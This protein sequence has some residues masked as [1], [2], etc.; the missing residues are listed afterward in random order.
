MDNRNRR[1]HANDNT[2]NLND[3]RTPFLLLLFLAILSGERTQGQERLFISFPA[4]EGSRVVF[5][6]SSETHEAIRRTSPSSAFRMNYPFL[7]AWMNIIAAENLSEAQLDSLDAR[8]SLVRSCVRMWLAHEGNVLHSEFSILVADTAFFSDA[9]LQ[10]LHHSITTTEFRIGS[11]TIEP[12]SP[13]D[14]QSSSHFLL[15][16]PLYANEPLLPTDNLMLLPPE[17]TASYFTADK[18][19]STSRKP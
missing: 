1:L 12:T 19:K 8:D 2:L 3:M 14:E 6:P 13:P 5:I 4:N 18:K 9:T 7:Q 15:I 17:T 10:S 16:L 11:D